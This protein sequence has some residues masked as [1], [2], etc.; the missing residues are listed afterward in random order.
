MALTETRPETPAPG[1]A[2]NGSSGGTPAPTTIDGL[3]G[4]GD[5]KTVGRVF[6]WGGVIGL[7]GGL[8]LAQFLG[9]A[10]PLGPLMQGAAY[11]RFE[12]AR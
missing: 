2:E 4:T 10:V 11:A 8:V 3:L 5:H 1:S 7:I 6:I 9:S 12:R